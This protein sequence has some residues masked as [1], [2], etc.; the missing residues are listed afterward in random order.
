MDTECFVSQP[1][2]DL[3]IRWMEENNGPLRTQREESGR[4]EEANA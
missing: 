3:T 4:L 2:T 1:L